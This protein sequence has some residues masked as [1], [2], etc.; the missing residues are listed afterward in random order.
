VRSA[1]DGSCMRVLLSCLQ[2][3]RRHEIPAYGFWREYFVE[4]C[5]EAG[6]EVI[7][8][9]DVDWAEALTFPEGSAELVAWR[10]RTWE[11][12]V[13]FAKREQSSDRIDFFLGYLYPQQVE[14]AAVRE[15][16]RMGIPCVNFFCDNV[17]EFRKVPAAY[18]PF[19][20]HW[21]PEYEA[22][23]MYRQA[24]LPHIHAAMPCWVPQHLRV[25]PDKE[26][27][28]AVFIGSADILRRNLF[29]EAIAAGADLALH[30]KGWIQSSGEAAPF[31]AK[32]D[33]FLATQTAFLCRH[34]LH[35]VRSKI[36]DKL[37]PLPEIGIPQSSVGRLLSPEDYVRVTK[38]A[39]VVLGASRVPSPA[40]SLRNPLKYS[41]LRDIEAPML[42]ACYL[43]EYTEGLAS[44]Y[45]VG[46]DV[47]S[48]GSADELASK[49]KELL[50]DSEK[51][52]RL[53]I[54]GQQ[55]ALSEHS[56]PATLAKIGFR[57]GVAFK[58]KRDPNI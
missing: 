51:R 8:V 44:L 13:A 32:K 18:A 50:S 54:S 22:L 3:V 41:R 20:L 2:S 37:F 25:L 45:N 1:D 47:E 17:R 11:R 57:L 12:A 14:E 35:G 38:E 23:P 6:V 39:P 29:S 36:V 30:G 56:V 9:P 58:P 21:V 43:T 7:E 27:G 10:S 34:G 52:R 28:A 31:R 46:E 49:L 55:K 5:R 33:G 26:E 53:R 4:G 19:D 15:M 40:R 48:F 42:G 24:R 16:Q